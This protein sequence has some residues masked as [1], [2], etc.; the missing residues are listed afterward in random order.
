M[1]NLYTKKI[2]NWQRFGSRGQNWTGL[3]PNR[4]KKLKTESN[5]ET[6]KI[7]PTI[8]PL[9]TRASVL[10]FKL[11]QDSKFKIVNFKIKIFHYFKFLKF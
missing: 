3:K 9:K 5:P 10:V 6:V 8:K 1:S 11:D 4:L 7:F 2:N